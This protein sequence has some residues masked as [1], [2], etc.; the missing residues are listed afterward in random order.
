MQH[1]STGVK[2]LHVARLRTDRLLIFRP[3]FGLALLRG[4]QDRIE[5]TLSLTWEDDRSCTDTVPGMHHQ[6]EPWLRE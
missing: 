1:T 5:V 2:N 4:R 3:P 6:T